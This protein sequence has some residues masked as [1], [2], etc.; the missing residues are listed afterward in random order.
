MTHPLPNTAQTQLEQEMF[1]C[2][3]FSVL[4]EDVV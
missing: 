2:S 3:F 4:F 1:D